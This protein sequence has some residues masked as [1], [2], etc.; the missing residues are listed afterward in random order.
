MAAYRDCSAPSYEIIRHTSTTGAADVVAEGELKPEVKLNLDN[1]TLPM[2]KL[3]C[4]SAVSW[5]VISDYDRFTSYLQLELPLRVVDVE[6]SSLLYGGMSDGKIT[7][8]P[9]PKHPHVRCCGCYRPK[10]LDCVEE[11]I[12]ALRS[13]PALAEPDLFVTSP[14]SWSALRRIKDDLHRYILS[15]DPTQGEAMSLWGVETLVTTQCSPGDGFLID[16]TKFGKAIIREGLTFRQ[17]TA[18]DDFVRNLLRWIV[19][20]RLNLGVERPS[21]V[22]MMSNLPT[23]STSGTW[24]S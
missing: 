23:T 18:E 10:A 9:T 7:G 12:E 24:S 6:N 17:G 11:A 20:E 21:A 16:T 2:I 13:G 5:E 4:N 3:A 15:P 19:E 14:S 1:V 22:L 8:L